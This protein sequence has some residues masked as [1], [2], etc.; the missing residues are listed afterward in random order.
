MNRTNLSATALLLCL[1]PSV[2]FAHT[3]IGDASGLSHGLIH[4]VSG[5][6]HV[7]AMVTVGLFAAH[8]GG[9]ALWLVPASFMAMM[10]VGGVLGFE[11]VGM[12]FVE[13][14]IA[15]SVI[16][17]GATVAL[18]WSP[19]L[20]GA[21][22]LVGLFALFHGHAHG[23]ELPAGAAAAD[24]AAGFLLA[25]AG[26]HALGVAVGLGLSRLAAAPLKRVSQVGGTGIAL[27]GLALLLGAL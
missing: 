13:V 2:A 11:G 19:P 14:G 25:T 5:L 21:T 20:A 24:Y 3:G 10:A 23:A 18:R 4:P 22:G 1:A 6:D 7:L 9:R 8:L 12:P 17:L 15:L 26:L 16:V 27:A